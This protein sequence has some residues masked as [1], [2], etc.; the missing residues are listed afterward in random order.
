MRR[1]AIFVTAL[2]SVTGIVAVPAAEAASVAQ[3]HRTAVECPASAEGGALAG[4]EVSP[5]PPDRWLFEPCG[6]VSACVVYTGQDMCDRTQRMRAHR[7]GGDAYTRDCGS[8]AVMVQWGCPADT[9]RQPPTPSTD[10]AAGCSIA[11][12]FDDLATA[13]NHPGA[14]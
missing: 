7:P 1:L 11:W 13:G 3:H 4:C 2:V 6:I 10:P 5:E 14:A 8:R 9:P 12:Y